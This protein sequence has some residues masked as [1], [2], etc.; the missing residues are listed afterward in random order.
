MRVV[1]LARAIGPECQLDVVGIRPGE[2]LHEIMIPE[3]E[4]RNCVEFADRYAILPGHFGVDVA[5]YQARHR[6]T[7]CA[8]DF[9]YSS[10]RNDHWLSVADLRQIV[11]AEPDGESKEKRIAA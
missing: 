9:S 5:A 4:A 2:K 1:D 3:D 11:G 7:R 8:D 6:G 10:D